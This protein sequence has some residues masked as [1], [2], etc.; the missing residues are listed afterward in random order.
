MFRPGY[1]EVLPDYFSTEADHRLRVMLRPGYNG[2]LPHYLAT[3]ADHRLRV[4]F[5]YENSRIHYFITSFLRLSV[6][7]L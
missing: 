3:E 7:L 6:E 5:L 1:N 4:M 2:A